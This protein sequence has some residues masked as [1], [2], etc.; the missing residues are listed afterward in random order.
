M[1][2]E[3]QS[4]MLIVSR[5]FLGMPFQGL[6]CPKRPDATGMRTDKLLHSSVDEEEVINEFFVGQTVC[7]ADWADCLSFVRL[8]MLEKM[9]AVLVAVADETLAAHAASFGDQLALLLLRLRVEFGLD[10]DRRTGFRVIR[11]RSAN[12]AGKRIIH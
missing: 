2:L 4:Q 8:Q 11:R 1:M 5:M 3:L 12:L 9:Q 10:D 6:P 7:L